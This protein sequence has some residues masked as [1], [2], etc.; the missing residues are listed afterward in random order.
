MLAK[1]MG[2]G[3]TVISEPDQGS[4][5]R[6]ELQ[7]APAAEAFSDA[8]SV[9]LETT[10]QL[11]PCRVLLAED[12]Q[13]NRLLIRKYL[14]GQPVELAEAANAAPLWTCAKSCS[15]ILF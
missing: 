14:R 10:P 8:A 5:F 3:I 13:T 1:R 7:M 12:N 6:L 2:G 4:C 11:P 15:R 9:S